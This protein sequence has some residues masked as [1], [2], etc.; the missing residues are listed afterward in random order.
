MHLQPWRA[1]FEM[2]V[3]LQEKPVFFVQVCEVAA[4]RGGVAMGV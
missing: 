1:V 3:L 2:Y 4:L